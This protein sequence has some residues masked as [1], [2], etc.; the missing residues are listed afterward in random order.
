MPEKSNSKILRLGLKTFLLLLIFFWPLLQG[1]S[2][3]ETQD[4]KLAILPFQINAAS[5]LSYLEEDLPSMLADRL[6]E[7]GFTVISQE[8]T[9]QLLRQEGVEYLDLAV[10]RD[11]AVLADAEYAVYGSLNQVE[12][13]ISMDVRL[14]EAFG[15]KEVKALFVSKKGLINIL[16][17]IDELANKISDE[18]L[19]KE[20]IAEIEVTGNEILEK[21]VVL[22]RLKIQEGDIYDPQALNKEVK[23]LY[24]LGYFEDVQVKVEDIQD[25]KKVIFN[26]KEKPLIQAIG[27]KG[28]E[29]INKDDIL[30]VMNTKTGS[31]LNPQVISQDLEK[32]RALYH[33]KGY[34]QVEA[35]YELEQTDPR[36]ARLNVIIKEGEK[37]FIKEIRIKGAQKLDPGDLKD[38]LALS[39]RGWF[40][41]L[42]GKGVLKRELLDRDAAALEA[43]YSNRGFMDVQVGQPEVE[44][45]E[46]GIYITFHVLEG[47]R[48][49]VGE[50]NIRGELIESAEKLK[51]KTEMDKLAAEDDYFD[52]SILHKD[53]QTLSDYYSNYGYAFAEAD[54]QIGKE[55]KDKKINVTYV[56]NK[57]QKV[58]IR[59]VLVEGNT[60][61]RDNVI[62]RE[63][64]LADGSLFKGSKL[65]RSNERLRKLDYFESV[66]IETVPT[67]ERDEL[68]LKVKVKEKSTGMLSLGAG[69]SSYDGVFVGGQIQERNLFGKGY[70]LGF[71]GTFGGRS[72][73]YEMNFMNP[74]LYDGPLGVGF[75]AYNTE[76]EYDDYDKDTTGGKIKF[77]YPLGEYTNLF[78]SYRLESY[79]IKNV[80]DEADQ[81]IK[82]IKGDNLASVAYIAAKRDTTNRRINPD[83]GTVHTLSL[84][85]GGGLLSGDDN[86]IKYKWDSSFYHPMPWETTF[87]WHGQVGYLMENTDEEVPDFERFYLGGINSLRGYESRSIPPENAQGEEVGGY[88]KFFTNFEYLVPLYEEMGILGLVF[89]DAGNVWKKGE[90]LDTDLYKSIG[91]GIRW[92]SPFGPLRLEYGYPLDKFDDNDS[93]RFEFSVGQFF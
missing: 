5:E 56:L 27:V 74:H 65:Q 24:G 73:R 81:D 60:K 12:E 25:G 82:D 3:Q 79:T 43:Y 62:R 6:K 86:F 16:P 29:E 80:A 78:W 4:I 90:D 72:T 40:S 91:A 8:K 30:E 83:R 53:T 47:E 26:V 41:W 44:F 20:T 50:V 63:M 55:E 21:D 1:A 52:R 42:T 39:E 57:G 70:R 45:K 37:Q 88:K 13:T 76:Y 36:K 15:L 38:E 19:R 68:D 23:R 35:S 75:D 11:L 51:Q 34:Y 46:D 33:K 28:N 84:E 69:Y 48:Y 10:S 22:M 77:S 32:I 14:V 7:K 2:A 87:H 49:K 58:Y 67:D 31:V 18:L 89:F 64:R 85:Y 17:A 54:A 93:G 61:T 71:K 92:Y 59:R 9:M 66:D